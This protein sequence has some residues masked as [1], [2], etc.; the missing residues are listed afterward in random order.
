MFPLPWNF[1]F[2]KKDGTVVDI[3]DAMGGGGGEPY[4]LPTASS[5]VKGGVKIGAGLAMDGEVLKN[6][7]PT[8]PTPYVLPTASAETLGGVKVGSGLSIEDGVLSAAAGSLTLL[9]E[10]DGHYAETTYDITLSSGDY[11]YLLC[12]ALPRGEDL[13]TRFICPLPKQQKCYLS[14]FKVSGAPE[15]E[16]GSR[17][18]TFTDATHLSM[19]IGTKIYI[20]ASSSTWG[21]VDNTRVIPFKIYGVK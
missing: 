16:A 12:E 19:A 8:P 21:S 2:R 13:T 11:S 3:N 6:L 20:S 7:N 10:N 17:E 15:M 9:W 5:E 4:V 14:Y 18:V 1:P